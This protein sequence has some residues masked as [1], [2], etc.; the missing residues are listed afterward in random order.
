MARPAV[1]VGL[2]MSVVNGVLSLRWQGQ[3]MCPVRIPEPRYLSTPD[4]T[5]IAYQVLGDGPIDIAW[6]LDS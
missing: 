1:L 2:R 4:G 3:S 6:Q 5:Y